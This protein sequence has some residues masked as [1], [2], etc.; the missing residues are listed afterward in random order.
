MISLLAVISLLGILDGRI[1]GFDAGDSKVLRKEKA[2]SSENKTITL[3]P[4]QKAGSVSVEEAIA[5]RRSKRAFSVKPIEIEKLSQLLW[6]AQGITDEVGGFKRAA[7]SAGA[8]Y[9]LEIFVIV[10]QVSGLEP[11]LYH[12]LPF[13]HHLELIE[14]GDLRVRLA[15]A[16][17][18]QR[19]I[20]SA[21]LS[22]VITAEYE[23]VTGKYGQRG[24]TYTH[25]EVGHVGENLFLQAEAIGLATV[26]VGA[27]YDEPVSKLLNLSSGVTPLYIMPF[28]YPVQ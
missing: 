8:L 26:P 4:P 17:L 24:V 28:G 6:A 14:S 12:Y 11:G 10:G 20:A 18:S 3:P 27:F 2:V 1:G 5:K 15:R 9:P 23:R 21:P 19:F 22:I 25:I 13:L 7:P 16:A